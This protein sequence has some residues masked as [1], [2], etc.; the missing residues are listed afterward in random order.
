[1]CRGDDDPWRCEEVQRDTWRNPH[2]EGVE[3]AVKG[4]D[5]NIPVAGSYQKGS[6]RRPVLKQTCK[7]FRLA[8]KT[9]TPEK[10]LFK[11]TI[12]G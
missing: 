4:T 9:Y 2:V 12:F 5:N 10:I 11:T 8:E 3:S 7:N 1:M 6:V